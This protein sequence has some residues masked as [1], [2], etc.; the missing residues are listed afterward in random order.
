MKNIHCSIARIFHL[1]TLIV[2]NYTISNT[3]I[4]DFHSVE[5]NGGLFF[6]GGSIIASG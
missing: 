4:E 1:N 5:R 2:V 6:M 3:D